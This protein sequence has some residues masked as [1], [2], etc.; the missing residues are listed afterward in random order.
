MPDCSPKVIAS[1]GDYTPTPIAKSTHAETPTSTGLT[2]SSW[3]TAGTWEER[4]CTDLVKNQLSSVLNR[5]AVPSCNVS[6]VEKVEGEAQIV[7]ARGKKRHLF[8]FTA[9]V[10]LSIS[11]DG[12]D[13]A[14]KVSLSLTDISPQSILE[15]TVKWPKSYT[16]EV[17]TQLLR[18]VT[19]W[20]QT[21]RTEIA[22]WEEEY[23]A[24]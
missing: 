3:N 9:D 20:H 19:Q 10:D 8:D 14:R 21:L 5:V 6:K 16:T 13:K 1:S 24:L 11:L 23:K 2:T 18:V 17:K 7:W 4:D 22:V 15:Y 12:S